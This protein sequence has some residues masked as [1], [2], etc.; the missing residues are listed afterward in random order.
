MIVSKKFASF[1]VARIAKHQPYGIAAWTEVIDQQTWHVFEEE[2][3]G[4]SIRWRFKNIF[5][6][7]S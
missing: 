5:V 2:V 1:V 6:P 3:V 7:P 4:S